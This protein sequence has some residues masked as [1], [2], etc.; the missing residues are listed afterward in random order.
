[1]R[2]LRSILVVTASALAPA[3]W[4]ATPSAQ[5][6][7]PVQWRVENPFRFFKEPADT[8]LHRD[9][10]LRL[11][12]ALGRE[13]T[14]REIEHD[15]AVKTDG[16]GWAERFTGDKL[17]DLVNY[18]YC[19][20]RKDTTCTSPGYIRPA[21][22]RILVKVDGVTGECEFRLGGRRTESKAGRPC[23]KETP[24]DL[25]YPEGG[26]LSVYK[27]GK[28]IAG[29]DATVTVR[30]ML[31]IGLGDSFASGEGNPNKA[32]ALHA[33]DFLTYDTGSEN[34]QRRGFPAR[35]GEYASTRDK[36][37]KS[38]SAQWLHRPCHR[39]VYS[40]QLRSALHLAIAGEA[41]HH[42]VTYV[43]LACTGAAILD[44]LFD[45]WSGSE[46]A[47]EPE[48]VV[49]LGQLN[50]AARAVCAG[51]STATGDTRY[52]LTS[53]DHDE[54][55]GVQVSRQLERCA[56]DKARKP[57]LVLL[58]IGGNDVGFSGLVAGATLRLDDLTAQLADW[59]NN[60]PT[61]SVEDAQVMLEPL[62]ANYAALKAAI[63]DVL[64]LASDA[65]RRRVVMTAYPMMAYGS[66]GKVCPAGNAG[67][68]GSELFSLNPAA[69]E[70]VE[71]FIADTLHPEM[72]RAAADN[73]WTFVEA[74]R[75]QF[76]PQGFCAKGAAQGYDTAVEVRMPRRRG[77]RPDAGDV[78]ASASEA[79]ARAAIGS[80]RAAAAVR[81][82][83]FP[84]WNWQPGDHRAFPVFKPYWPRERWVRTPNDAFLTAHM[85][86][87]GATSFETLARFMG[88]SGAFHPTAG[89]HAA[90]ADAVVAKVRETGVLE[91]R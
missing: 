12:A 75:P 53:Y 76:K 22:H 64:H 42:A 40:Q 21:S 19:W 38:Q 30:D 83:G 55:A 66:D 6:L 10:Y 50:G 1:M 63:A 17:K 84:Q 58:S 59:T 11:R 70:K 80:S 13:P 69:A 16:R 2:S 37:F 18:D 68:D 78:I 74:H 27:D 14:V 26:T 31:V 4:P 41:Q 51:T 24:F 56:A 82:R 47:S 79:R 39:S 45:R 49:D 57:D 35:I 3:L 72:A 36:G 90:I 48:D 5:Q 33:R 73:G 77:P 65:E 29:D 89:G 8:K 44:G 86:E 85:H 62:K 34:W 88:Y 9:A 23:D 25:P 52:S 91:G 81:E 46:K 43:G 67:M 15:L 71:A 32:V 54:E 28:R 87:D 20:H 61:S 60:N 7:S